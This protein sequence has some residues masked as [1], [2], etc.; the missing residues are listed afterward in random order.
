ANR[1][2]WGRTVLWAVL[3][4]FGAVIVVGSLAEI[5]AQS[6]GY[7]AST[8]TGYAALASQV[9]EASTATGRRLATLMEK[10]PT[11]ANVP[12]RNTPGRTARVEIQQGLDEAVT[13]TGR[14]A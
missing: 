6:G 1:R 10:A 8:N 2:S 4:A 3:V 12:F 13:E 5:N 7:R 11:L 9:V 14:E